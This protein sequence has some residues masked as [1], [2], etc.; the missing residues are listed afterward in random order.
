MSARGSPARTVEN[1]VSMPKKPK[2]AEFHIMKIGATPARL[3]AVVRATDEKA[4]LA[5]VIARHRIPPHVQKRLFVV[6]AA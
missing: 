2:L 3:V 1:R 4:A 5:E 6:R